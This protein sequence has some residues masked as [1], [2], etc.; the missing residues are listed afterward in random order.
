MIAWAVELISSS[1]SGP[2]PV[3][4]EVNLSARSLTDPD[5]PRDVERLLESAS[6]D[7]ARLVFEIT[8]TTAI[9]NMEQASQFAASLRELGCSLALD[10]FGAGFAS[11]YY[12]KHLPL[13]ALKVD[14]AFVR[15]LRV[16]PI[17]RLLVKHMAEIAS[18]LGLLTIAEYVEDAETLELL[19]ELGIDAAQGFHVGGPAPMSEFIATPTDHL[20]E[21]VS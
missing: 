4:F 12:L 16:N 20:R 14:G 13:D 2:Q 7:P 15:E 5:L 6:A 18:S 11:F 10:D 1:A 17:D 21:P 8:E 19:A 9:A 3:A